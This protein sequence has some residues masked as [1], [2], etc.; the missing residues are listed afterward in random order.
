MKP[1]RADFIYSKHLWTSLRSVTTKVFEI[2]SSLFFY[3]DDVH[4][5][6]YRMLKFVVVNL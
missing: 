2:E 4:F 1:E 6:V 5:Y 3:G